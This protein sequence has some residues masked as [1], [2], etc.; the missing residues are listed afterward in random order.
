M[1]I[2]TFVRHGNAV[3]AEGQPDSARKLSTKGHD[4]ARARRSLLGNPEFDLVLFSPTDRTKQT[5]ELVAGGFEACLA[6]D[7]E[8]L[9]T[10]K[11]PDGE[12]LDEMFKRLAYSP[13][14]AYQK[15]ERWDCLERYAQN[16]WRAILDEIENTGGENILVVG[17]AVYLPIIGYTATEGT[18]TELL[19]CNMGECGAIQ[20]AFNENMDVVET[21]ILDE[22]NVVTA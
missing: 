21:R 9:F 22:V 10:P 7:V 12:A 16:A 19:G 8:E 2:I 4:Q 6:Y 14:S 18:F 3:K 17:H 15:E 5:A 11:G 1:P 20:I 13:L